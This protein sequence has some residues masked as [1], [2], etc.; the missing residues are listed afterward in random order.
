MGSF[1]LDRTKIKIERVGGTKK[2]CPNIAAENSL[3]AILHQVN[4][5]KIEDSKL[6]LLKDKSEVLVFYALQK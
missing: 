1:E 4:Q 2:N 5:F 6:I 3:L